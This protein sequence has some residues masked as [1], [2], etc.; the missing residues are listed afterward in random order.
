MLLTTI[1]AYKESDGGSLGTTHVLEIAHVSEDADALESLAQPHLVGKNTCRTAVKHGENST[2]GDN[3]APQGS[4]N[5]ETKLRSASNISIALTPATEQ[6][7]SQARHNRQSHTVS[8]CAQLLSR[9]NRVPGILS[10]S[11]AAGHCSIK[12]RQREKSSQTHK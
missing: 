1:S 8:C 7:T 3:S 4:R 12:K 6:P 5:R 9:T 10:S 11:P 2:Q